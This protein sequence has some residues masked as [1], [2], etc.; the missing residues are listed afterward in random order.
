VNFVVGGEIMGYELEVKCDECGDALDERSDIYCKD[1]YDKR[2]D[3]DEVEEREEE[4][5]EEIKRLEEE[6][7]EL[8]T[9]VEK[10]KK[11]LPLDTALN[12]MEAVKE[13]A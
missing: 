12:T 4:M 2:V 5:K 10:Y 11:L 13:E 6:V 9:L 3:P 8:A 7:G 1:C